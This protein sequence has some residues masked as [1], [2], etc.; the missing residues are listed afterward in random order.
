MGVGWAVVGLTP[1]QRDETTQRHDRPM[2]RPAVLLGV[3]RTR[4]GVSGVQQ[5]GPRARNTLVGMHA[6]MHGVHDTKHSR[7]ERGGSYSSCS[8][9]TPVQQKHLVM[10]GPGG[11]A[12]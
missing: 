2:P 1:R 8:N 12:S 9:G 5:H 3:L 11:P 4:S 10:Q 6:C 7:T